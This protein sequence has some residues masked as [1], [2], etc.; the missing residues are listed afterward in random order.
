MTIG[1]PLGL[2]IALGALG[3]CAH[4]TGLVDED[5]DFDPKSAYL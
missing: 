5:D 1:R 4:S 2:G 3:G